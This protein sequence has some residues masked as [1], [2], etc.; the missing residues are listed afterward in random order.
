MKT[1]RGFLNWIVGGAAA[2]AVLG[3]HARGVDVAEDEGDRTAFNFTC[4][5]GEG[6]CAEVP[7]EVGGK[8]TLDCTCGIQWE[9]EWTGENFKTKMR[10]PNAENEDSHNFVEATR[11]AAE[12]MRGEPVETSGAYVPDDFETNDA[13]GG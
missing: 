12:E 2:S 7:K 9:L 8:L 1:R 13:L 3:A 4:A 6:M 11:K 10:N 5:C